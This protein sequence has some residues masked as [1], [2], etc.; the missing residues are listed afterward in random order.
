MNSTVTVR[1]FGEL[2]AGS[3][4]SA[5][6]ISELSRL[7][8][9]VFAI[10]R[11]G[12]LKASN[13]VGC[14]TTSS[15]AVIE[16]LPKI[17]L[18]NSREAN[19]EKTKAIFLKMLRHWRFGNNFRHLPDSDIKKLSRFPMLEVFV[20]LFLRN[21]QEIVRSGLARKYVEIEENLP[22]LR[23]RIKFAGHLRDN[24]NDRSRFYVLHDDYSENRPANRLIHTVLQILEAQLTDSRNSQLLHE[25]KSTFVDIP[26]STNIHADWQNVNIDR[27][28]PHYQPVM[29]YV[30][31]FLFNFGLVTYSGRYKNI[32]LLFPMEEV[33]EDFVT[34]CFRKYQKHYAVRTQGPQ[35]GLAKKDGENAFLMKPDISLMSGNS[36]RFVLDAKWKRLNVSVDSPK[37]KIDQS[38]MYQLFAYGMHY[39]CKKVAMLYPKNSDFSKHLSY[40]FKINY[41]E[42]LCLPFDLENPQRSVE[43]AISLL[44][45]FSSVDSNRR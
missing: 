14:T 21:V 33:F 16:I 7:G 32:S 29:Q 5:Q 24:L 31:L 12:K 11:N 34:F 30:E 15:G 43:T 38:D 1:E 2:K 13:Y 17:D 22:F 26:A 28:M 35:R 39:D 20:Y 41:L 23:G 27:T 40:R 4:L 44:N 19:E 42:L 25:V 45:D 9:S 36:V 37:H 10:D 8:S 6:D 3:K 18:G